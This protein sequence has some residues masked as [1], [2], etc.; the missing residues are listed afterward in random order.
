MQGADRN[1]R[2]VQI[3]L[4]TV[5]ALLPLTVLGFIVGGWFSMFGGGV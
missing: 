5:F 1:E 2:P 3:V 4:I